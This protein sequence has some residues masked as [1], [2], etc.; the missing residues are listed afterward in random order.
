MENYKETAEYK[1]LTA[2]Q[3]AFFDEMEALP[4]EKRREA[5][6]LFYCCLECIKKGIKLPEPEE[7]VPVFH[8][9]YI[10]HMI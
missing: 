7:F 5:H 1:A 2:R 4:D 3:R 9:W 8:E 10:S 6:A